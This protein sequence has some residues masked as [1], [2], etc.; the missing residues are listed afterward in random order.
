MTVRS[1]NKR[2]QGPRRFNKQVTEHYYRLIN[3]QGYD[4]GFAATEAGG[5]G[6]LYVCLNPGLRIDVPA[7]QD[8]DRDMCLWSSNPK[9]M[10]Q[11]CEK[12]GTAYFLNIETPE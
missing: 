4:L 3:G 5:D 9:F 1:K 6:S 2:S 10:R 7:T 8:Q 12:F 11:Y